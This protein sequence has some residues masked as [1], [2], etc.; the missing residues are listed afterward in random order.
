MFKNTEKNEFG[1]KLMN[2][3]VTGE[4]SETLLTIADVSD[5]MRPDDGF[6]GALPNG[7]ETTKY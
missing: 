4:L 5:K 3:P 2:R 1:L 7:T 6:V